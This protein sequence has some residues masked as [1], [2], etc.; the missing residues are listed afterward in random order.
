MRHASDFDPSRKRQTLKEESVL[1]EFTSETTETVGQMVVFMQIGLMFA[2][3]AAF[4]LL[5]T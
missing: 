4:L 5:S 1:A 3:D 2:S